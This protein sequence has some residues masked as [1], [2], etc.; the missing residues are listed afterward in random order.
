MDQYQCSKWARKCRHTVPVLH[1]V[2]EFH[3]GTYI[4]AYIRLSF[5]IFLT[6]YPVSLL[7]NIP[8][9]LNFRFEY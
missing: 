5:K 4:L 2:P 8:A 7:R 6:V 3:T 9:V 1:F